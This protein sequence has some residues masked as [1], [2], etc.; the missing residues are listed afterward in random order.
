MTLASTA[1]DFILSIRSQS[2]ASRMR[3]GGFGPLF[4][5]FDADR[6]TTGAERTREGIH[7]L[8]RFEDE[9]GAL[10]RLAEHHP[11]TKTERPHR[12]GR[13]RGLKSG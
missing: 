5:V 6:W 8:E 4:H 3:H 11:G 7:I 1:M 10:H 9:A 13:E 2:L 12:F